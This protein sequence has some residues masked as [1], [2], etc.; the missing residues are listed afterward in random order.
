MRNA[1]SINI[2]KLKQDLRAAQ[3]LKDSKDMARR[4]QSTSPQPSHFL[5]NNQKGF[6][7]SPKTSENAKRPIWLVNKNMKTNVINRRNI[8]TSHGQSPIKVSNQVVPQEMIE[9][10]TKLGSSK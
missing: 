4:H 9:L 7:R 6:S 5:F 10:T 8:Q 3:H 1:I 2:V